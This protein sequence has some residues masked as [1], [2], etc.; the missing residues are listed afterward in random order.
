[1]IR[2]ALALASR[3]RL[4]ILIFHRVLPLADPLLPEEP[5]AAQF[6]ALL[7]HLQKRFNVLSLA[8]GVERLYGGTLP[9]SAL[10]ITFD[11][12]YADNVAVAAPLL[13]KHGVPAT[14][15]IATRF[16]DGGAMWNDMVIEAFRSTKRSELNLESLDLGRHSVAS[17]DARRLAMD[18]VLN[19]LKYREERQ[20]EAQACA[21]LE[22]AGAEPPAALM[23]T[24][25]QIRSL[26]GFGLQVGA[27]TV[28]HPILARLPS[29]KAW[30]E[31]CDSKRA[32]EQ[33]LGHP[34]TLFAYPNGRPQQDYAL[35]HVRM[36][37]EA[38]FD[39]AVS[40]AWG[41]ATDASDRMQLPR[42]TPWTRKPLKF[43]LLMLRN[44]RHVSRQDAATC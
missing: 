22:A 8:D 33:L 14:I 17:T 34:V 4:S 1:M 11:D 41:A 35:E 29:D 16:V 43:D 5:T 15:F 32:L 18:R 38:G 7:G 30:R 37:H 36:V 19:Q 12:G 23:M 3:G 13:R 31:I 21:I 27:H 28:S 42:F 24:H 20:R 40:T 25:D 44:L 10:A 9:G 39:A 6:D 26:A 2:S